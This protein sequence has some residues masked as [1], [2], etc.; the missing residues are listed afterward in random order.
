MTVYVNPAND[1][2]SALVVG[3]TEATLSLW[4]IAGVLAAVAVVVPLIAR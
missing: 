3:S 4:V 2:E 1:D